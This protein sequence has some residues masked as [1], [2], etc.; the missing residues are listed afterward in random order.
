[1]WPSGAAL[2]TIPPATVPPALGRLSTTTCCPQAS[3]SFG[4]IM[5][6]RRS[7]ALPAVNGTTMRIGRAG[8]SAAVAGP[9]KETANIAINVRICIVILFRT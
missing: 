1:V 8:Y 6:A 4:P 9:V 5:R 2:A 3:R 7:L